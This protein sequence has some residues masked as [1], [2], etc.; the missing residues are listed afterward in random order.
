MHAYDRICE[1]LKIKLF[2]NLKYIFPKLCRK[3]IDLTCLI[4]SI[5]MTIIIY[6][7]LLLLL[8]RLRS[9]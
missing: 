5:I 9:M 7:I 1:K 8:V 2:L 3:Y 4:N 6:T